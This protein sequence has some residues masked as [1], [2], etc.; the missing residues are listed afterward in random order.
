MGIGYP[1]FSLSRLSWNL[2]FVRHLQNNELKYFY[3]LLIFHL[4][5]LCYHQKNWWF[6]HLENH[7][8]HNKYIQY[9]KTFHPFFD[10]WREL[11]DNFHMHILLWFDIFKLFIYQLLH[12]HF[13][14]TNLHQSFEFLGIFIFF[15]TYIISILLLIFLNRS[16]IY[17][18]NQMDFLVCFNWF[19]Y[20]Y[21][22]NIFYLQYFPY[23]LK[24]GTYLKKR[25]YNIIKEYW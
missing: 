22:M 6:S 19:L 14:G 1:F 12:L 5:I 11:E 2:H 17:T 7:I 4:S 20:Y 10:L 8:S 16:Y 24:I 25:I 15:L 21:I 23:R 3:P 9:S 13:L 18:I